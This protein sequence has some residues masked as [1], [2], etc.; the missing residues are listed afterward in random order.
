MEPLHKKRKVLIT[1]YFK[2]PENVLT[3]YP[4]DYQIQKINRRFLDLD[5]SRVFPPKIANLIFSELEQQVEYYSGELARAKVF[6]KWYPIRRQHVVYGEIGLTY[7]FSG[8]KIP[9]KPWTPLLEHLRSCVERICGHKFNF[10]LLNRY[11]NGHDYI[12]L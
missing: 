7:T 9:T 10:V 5:Y 1:E 8:V 2:E 3:F 4:I 6:N 11:K 12:N